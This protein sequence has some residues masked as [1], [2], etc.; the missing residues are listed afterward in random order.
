MLREAEPRMSAAE[1]RTAAL[2]VHTGVEGLVLERLEGG[3]S[4]ELRRARALFLQLG[5]AH[6]VG[7]GAASGGAIL[8]RRGR[9]RTRSCAGRA[10]RRSE[11]GGW[12]AMLELRRRGFEMTTPPGLA[13]EPDTYRGQEGIRRYWESFYEVMEEIHVEAGE[14]FDE[15]EDWVLATFTL[16][17]R[18]GRPASRAASKG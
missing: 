14:E 13:A 5:R 4:A 6:A 8:L 2:F 15:I 9:D 3:D 12:E 11:G 17:A 16:R 1:A 10:S 7:V 18:A